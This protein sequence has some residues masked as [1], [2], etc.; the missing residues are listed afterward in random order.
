MTIRV[1]QA[2]VSKTPKNTENFKSS[3]YGWLLLDCDCMSLV[4]APNEPLSLQLTFDGLLRRIVRRLML[5]RI[6][7]MLLDVHS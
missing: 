4:N 7:D 6:R 2:L 3:L 1:E 5:M